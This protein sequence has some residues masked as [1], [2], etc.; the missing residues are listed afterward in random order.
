MATQEV[1]IRL[2]LRGRR[3]AA[4]GLRDTADEA[5][6]LG[7]EVQ[8]AGRKAA[9]AAR[10]LAAAADRRIT[11]GLRLA[12]RAA[13]G[14][15]G[16][17]GGVLAR[18][19][20][21]G[22]L[23][24]AGASVALGIFAVKA[25]GAASD[26]AETASA[27]GTV[28]ADATAP[29]QM[30]VDTTSAAFGIASSD[31]QAAM[32]RF[33]G[34]G[35]QTGLT[36]TALADFSSSITQAGLDLAS[37]WN[38]STDDA[39]AALQAGLTGEADGLKQFGIFMSD[40]SLSA[41]ALSRG[42]TK[43]VDSMTEQEKVGLRSRFI[44]AN[45]GDAQGDL[46]RTQDGLANKTRG[47]QGRFKTLTE[48]I[49]AA[50]LP[51]TSALTSAVSDGLAAAIDWLT[52]RIDGLTAKSKALGDQFVVASGQLPA[53]FAAIKG[54][55]VG[56]SAGVL[57]TMLGGGG[58]YVEPIRAGIETVIAKGRELGV[59]AG[60]IKAGLQA[61]PISPLKLLGWAL[62]FAANN[63]GLVKTALMILLPL[64]GAYRVAL[65]A[66]ALYSKGYAIAAGVA[67]AAQW[68]WNVALNA[69]PVGIITIAI[70][71][72]IAVIIGMVALVKHAYANWGWFKTA[73]DNA[74]LG[75][76]LVWGVIKQV[77]AAVGEYLLGKL[78][79]AKAK[80]D[81]VRDAVSGFISKVRTGIAVI[82]TL[83]ER[84]TNLPGVSMLADAG[85]AIGLPIPGRATGGDVAAGRPYIVGERRPE[86]FVPQV[87]GTILPTVPTPEE[88]PM[89]PMS[90]GPGG[91]LHVTLTLDG[92]TVG[93]AVVADFR[94]QLARA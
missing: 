48:M 73:V 56:A 6:R 35:K 42:I 44:L 36:G 2:S 46:A 80:F 53:L 38:V 12:T 93:A 41:F 5:D 67:T 89:T 9:R 69:N 86:L 64:W 60:E 37:F 62:T 66:V 72:V 54:G 15:G 11:S 47:V 30:W 75:L 17:M 10:G 7:E 77:A 90:A 18:G 82:K 68:L 55:D 88:T 22:A 59:V 33:A 8:G 94:R 32:L 78:I 20:Q 61:V 1:G 4:R 29:A 27:F 49:G 14:L 52:P 50:L 43:T 25:I 21:A 87:S 23:A 16:A 79:D 76:S 63:V 3:E 39:L 19:A 45:L 91:D 81:A 74:R 24:I 31:L 58:D 51:A 92:A 13:R 84:I 71:A 40:A 28:F 83:A 85:S 34:L 26:A 70:L 57:D 65:L